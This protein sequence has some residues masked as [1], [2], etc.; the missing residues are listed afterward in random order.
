MIPLLSLPLRAPRTTLVLLAAVTAAL[1]VHAGRIQLDSSFESLVSA[2]D[3]E[4]VFYEE[5]VEQFGSDQATQVGF[6]ADDVFTP[7]NLAVLD[8]LTER[9]SAV[10]GV[11]EAMSITSVRGIEPT[12]FG[13]RVGRLMAERPETPEDAARFKGVVLS[14]PLYVGNLVSRDARAAIVLV[15]FE[16]MTD[17]E[18]RRRGVAGSIERILREI[19]TPEPL[20]VTGFQ[21][22]K[23]HVAHMME[24]DLLG[25]V[26][27]LVLLIV[28]VLSWQ[29]RTFRGVLLPL[30]SVS[31]ALVWTL[32]A[33]A[34][35]GRAINLGTLALPPLLLAI[36][37]AYTIHL[38]NR[39][40]QELH[41]GRPRTEVVA[42]TMNEMRVPL[43]VA[44]LTTALGFASLA[45]SP[46]TATREMGVF[47]VVG[48]LAVLVLD[49]TFIPAALLLLPDLRTPPPAGEERY[50]RVAARIAALSRFAI[51]R[52]ALVF[53]G[54]ALLCLV[55]LGGARLLRVDT[56]YVGL[57]AAGSDVRRDHDRFA[58]TLGSTHP[59][60][61][62]LEGEGPNTLSRLENV[63]AL[64]E[65]QE[66]VNAQPGVG[67]TL[68]LADFVA[69][70]H[71]ALV[72][73]EESPMPEA[74]ADLSQLLLLLSADDLRPVV[75]RDFS[76]GNLLVK[77]A[78]S[79]S[80]DLR[81]FVERIESFA[82]GRFGNDVRVRATG[83]VVLLNRSADGLSHGQIAS[84]VQLLV[85]LL[86]LMSMLFLSLR[87]GLLSLVPNVVPVVV[88]FG[89]M[90]FAGI[91]LDFATSM[92]AVVSIG[93]AVDA[94]IHYL[95]AFNEHLHATGSQE[96]AIARVARQVGRPMVFTSAALA[97]GFF[98][99]SL[100]S[101][102]PVRAFGLLAAFTM[103]VALVA[104]VLLMPPLVMMTRI[105][106]LWDLLYVKL[107]PRPQEEIPLFAGLRPFQ[108]RIVVLMARLATAAPGTAITRRGEMRREL[109]LLIS[110]RVHVYRREGEELLRTLGRGDVLG[111][112]GLIRERPRSADV[113]AVERTEYLVLDAAFLERIRRRYPRIAAKLFINL[114]RTLS[115]RLES[116]TA[117]LARG[118][119]GEPEQA[120]RAG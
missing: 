90:G 61:V 79:G 53:G 7:E 58:E 23:V 80:T 37:I 3:P 109:Y 69:L 40:Y 104:H 20:A 97:A 25:F 66:F 21:T 118:E 82:R 99:I 83:I 46:I 71:R 34:L 116:T 48:I 119:I 75:N 43:A 89:F 102:Q 13:L 31:V 11:R 76:R 65:L 45:V 105:I 117:M 96:A 8:D 73:D 19:E 113:I 57:F 63:L 5:I 81:E 18:F 60:Y 2:R 108:A 30:A 86:L 103:V 33:M 68:S 9:L 101:L 85:V 24:R 32:G 110:G 1:G 91:P 44:A 41:L 26:P 51:D 52:R 77:T 74:Q 93:L 12:E 42:A 27:L 78:I 92:V 114:A 39:Y 120:Q 22:V 70:G 62:V 36:G 100:S 56:D 54:T 84:L 14:S 98:T 112:M 50:S 29:F 17:E 6:F 107:G 115:D 55:C 67:S 35:A 28:L 16:T 106:T 87:A 47:A 38:V 59:I 111:E 15:F 10:D 95:T 94:T 4:R 49:L 72:G 64:R 88:L